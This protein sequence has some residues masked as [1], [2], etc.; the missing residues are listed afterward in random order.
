M[1][2][3]PAL[4][5]TNSYRYEA[6]AQVLNDLGL[7]NGISTTSFE[8]DLGSALNRETGIVMLIRLFGLEAEAAGMT[9]A[10]EILS[11]FSDAGEI[12]DWAR[13]A[14]ACAIQRGLVIGLPDGTIGAKL[15]LNGK[16]Y[17]TLILRQLGYTPDYH[18]APSDL[19]A[20]G[21]IRAEEVVLY[22]DKDLIR[23]DLVGI[24]YGCLR[25][26]DR[27]GQSVLE[28]LVDQG[29]VERERAEAVILKA[30]D[31]RVALPT[32]AVTPVPTA[33]PAP[34]PT[35]TLS[36]T[37][38]PRPTV[39]PTMPP[40]YT[41]PPSSSDDS[42]DRVKPQASII[43]NQDNRVVVRFNEPVIAATSFNG[44][45]SLSNYK[46]LRIDNSFVENAASVSEKIPGVQ[47]EVSFNTLTHGSCGEFIISITGISDLSGNTMA[48]FQ[49]NLAV[50]PFSIVDIE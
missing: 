36:P 4:A 45:G 19:A 12:S 24:S 47:F 26:N 46:L 23:D 8:P 27:T 11:S 20:K 10:D 3:T 21:G 32:P 38:T 31:L 29:A 33:T 48:E 35:P 1:T 17:C 49:K 14:V 6:Q 5:G 37:P 22:I 28:N 16:S 43:Q 40:A 15:P 34:T 41:T 39:P 44:A 42:T 13:N 7:Y 25:V 50:I 9:N 18:Q 2:F 30:S